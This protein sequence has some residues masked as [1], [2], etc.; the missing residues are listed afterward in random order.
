[1]LLKDIRHWN[2]FHSIFYK[3]SWPRLISLLSDS[4]FMLWLQYKKRKKNRAAWICEAA[5][6]MRW[7]LLAN[8]SASRRLAMPISPRQEKRGRAACGNEC[9]VTI[10]QCHR[11]LLSV[12]VREM[13]S[14]AAGYEHCLRSACYL[15]Y[16]SPPI[17]KHILANLRRLTENSKS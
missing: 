9:E 16:T 14:T 8:Q 2:N 15:I 7:S 1:M 10:E 4:E 3:D 11:G 12:K 5:L 17:T 13:E 6:C